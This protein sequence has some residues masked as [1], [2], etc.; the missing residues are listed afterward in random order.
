MNAQL[1]DD[2]VRTWLLINSEEKDLKTATDHILQLNKNNDLVDAKNYVVRADVVSG[3][4]N[5]VVPVV[6]TGPERM[7]RIIGEIKKLNPIVKDMV[8]V[9]VENPNPSDLGFGDG[10]EG[11]YGPDK[12]NEWG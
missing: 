2:R 12:H 11:A 4:F 6:A 5:I 3:P 1:N 10:E 9:K 8:A 7:E